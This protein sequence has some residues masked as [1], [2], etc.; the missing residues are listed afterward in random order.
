MMKTKKREYPRISNLTD[1]QKSHLA[2]R[3]NHKTYLVISFS[4]LQI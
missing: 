1:R 3:L 2:W 4:H